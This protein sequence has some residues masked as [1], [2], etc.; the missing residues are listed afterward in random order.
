MRALWTDD[1]NRDGFLPKAAAQQWLQDDSIPQSL[2]E[3]VLYCF[4]IQAYSESHDRSYLVPVAGSKY[5]ANDIAQAYRTSFFNYGWDQFTLETGTTL[6]GVEA[7]AAFEEGLWDFNSPNVVEYFNLTRIFA[8]FYP[9]GFLGLDREQ[10]QRRF[11]LGQAAI[12]YT[13]AWDAPGIFSG[14]K[15]RDNPEDAFEIAIAAPPLPREN[16]RWAEYV[17]FRISEADVRGGVPFAINQQSPHFDRALNFLQ[18]LTSHRVNEAF[19]KKSGWLPVIDGAEASDLIADFSP[20]AEGLPKNLSISLWSGLP[21]SITNTW[22]ANLKLYMTGDISYEEFSE[23]V[24]DVL[25]NDTI[26]IRRAW[27]F[28]QQQAADQARSNNRTNSVEHLNTLLGVDQALDREI[29]ITYLNLVKDE[30]IQILRWWNLLHPD[31]PF[32]SF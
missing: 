8:E 12:I 22:T 9:T 32:P 24:R 15:N 30:G 1:S 29:A 11:V 7:L 20:K 6:S 23:K 13:G 25:A 10:A 3:L 19:N 26:G 27:I 17:P 21:S 31:Q 2:G 28:A 16:E 14:A 5:A 18:F 4:A